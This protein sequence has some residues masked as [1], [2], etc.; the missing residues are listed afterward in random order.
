MIFFLFVSMLVMY[1]TSTRFI[2][3]FICNDLY[4]T[5]FFIQVMLWCSTFFICAALQQKFIILVLVHYNDTNIW[6]SRL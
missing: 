6:E 3:K 1:K 5:I 2:F 4:V